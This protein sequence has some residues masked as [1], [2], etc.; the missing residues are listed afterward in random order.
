MVEASSFVNH[1]RSIRG[2]R[3]YFHAMAGNQGDHLIGMGAKQALQVAG[4][5]L[6]GDPA[7]A[8]V[9]MLNGGGAFN[10]Y[11]SG[12]IDELERHAQMYPRAQLLVGPQ[13][14]LLNEKLQTRMV[15]VVQQCADR[16]TLFA[17]EQRSLENLLKLSALAGKT[18]RCEISRD[19]AL[20]LGS[21]S[22]VEDCK[23]KATEEHVLVGLRNDVEA[24][25]PIQRKLAWIGRRLQWGGYVRSALMLRGVRRLMKVEQYPLSWR[26]MSE[27]PVLT[28]GK[29]RMRTDVSA[30]KTFDGFVD[31]IVSASFIITDRLHTAVLGYLLGKPVALV[32]GEHYY[33]VLSVYQY[34]MSGPGSTVMIYDPSGKRRLDLERA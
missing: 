9:I 31:P 23:Q 13:T 32:A 12:G 10:P 1:L 24:C 28:R 2:S 3:L 19:L 11:W 18:V 20:E 6:V 26:V 22:W 5:E 34:G 29:P 15:K 4:S 8:D 25:L 21:S 30:A 27:H 16:L 7:Q 17:R 33:K 14:Y